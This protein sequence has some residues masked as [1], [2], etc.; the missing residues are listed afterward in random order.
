MIDPATRRKIADISLKA[1]PEGFQLPRASAQIF[2]N[3]PQKREIAVVD[4]ASGKQTASWPLKGGDNF[5]M[6]LDDENQ[7]VVVAFRTPPRLGVFSA[8]GAPVWPMSK[9]AVMQTT[10]SS[11]ET[12]LG[13][14]EL[15][16]RLPGC[17]RHTRCHLPPCRAY[18]HGVGRAHVSIR[19]ELDRL[20]L[21]VRANAAEPAAI[22]IY[23][24]TP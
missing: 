12:T 17:V 9:R 21:A 8:R 10:S 24:P 3:V 11:Y 2:V 19:A 22:W 16:Q 18:S 23:R 7:H 15:R 1:H 20:L 14:R 4:I 13:L 6:A 5:P